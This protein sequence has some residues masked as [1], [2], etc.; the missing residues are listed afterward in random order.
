MEYI[1]Q[2]Y[3]LMESNGTEMYFDADE[4]VD[5][6]DYFEEEDDFDHYEKVLELGQKLHPENQDIKI[7]MCRALVYREDYDTALR[8]IERIGDPDDPELELLKMECF[9]ALDRFDEVW[10]YVEKKQAEN[11]DELEEIFEYL[12]PV[13]NELNCFNEAQ[14]LL[15]RG[16]AIFPDNLILKEEYCYYLEMQGQPQQALSICSELIDTDPYSADYWYMQGRLFLMQSDYDKAVDAFDFAL[17][18][19]DSDVEIKVMKAYCLF[20]NEHYEK[21]IDVYL[22]LLSDGH[23]SQNIQPYLAECYMKSEHFEQA[24]ALFKGLLDDLDIARGLTLYKNYIRCCLETGRENEAGKILPEMAARFPKDLLLLALQAFVHLATGEQDEAVEITVDILDAVY[25]AS[26]QGNRMPEMMK[27]MYS[28][29]QNVKQLIEEIH[30]L[31]E[32]Q[33]KKSYLPIHKAMNYLMEGDMKR[34]CRKYAKCP[35]EMI[36]GYLHRIFSTVRGFPDRLLTANGFL[37]ASEI[38]PR[39]AECVASDQLSSSYLTNGFHN[40]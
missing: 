29:G 16:L 18:C 6:L 37:Q 1:L 9:C 27:N 12:A 14:I 10:E 4:I 32:P 40:N 2:R 31:T 20:M 39:P 34:F 35:P 5:L 30:R 7:R 24:Y 13:M 38:H 28:L 25:Q 23:S 36:V 8:A 3:S 26:V 19:D 22:E 15:Q 11:S 33:V 21:A 17:A